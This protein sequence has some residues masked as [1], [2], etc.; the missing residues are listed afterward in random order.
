M[1]AAVYRDYGP[2][3]AV[4]KIEEIE[5]PIPKDEEVLIKIRAA[6]VNPLDSHLMKSGSGASFCTAMLE[7]R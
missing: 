4:L 7:E 2:P 5:K 1:K 6:S 3:E